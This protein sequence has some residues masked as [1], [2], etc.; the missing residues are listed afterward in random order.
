[1]SKRILILDDNVDFLTI[2]KRVLEGNGYDVRAISKPMEIEKNIEEFGPDVLIIDIYM[3]GRSG[4]DIVEEFRR[5]GV[6]GN[7]P[8]I[9]LTGID[10]DV[11]KMIAKYDGVAE[12][13]TKPYAGKVLLEALEKVFGK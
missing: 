2:E 9:F 1:M 8:K 5:R 3:P 7:I 13:I 10:D 6:Y 12:Y 4:F 11:D